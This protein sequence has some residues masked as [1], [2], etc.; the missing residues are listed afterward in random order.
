MAGDESGYISKKESHKT[1]RSKKKL[2]RMQ[3]QSGTVWQTASAR[4]RANIAL[5]KKEQQQWR[6]HETDEKKKHQN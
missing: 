1:S 5:E 3:A 4:D 6:Q 2:S